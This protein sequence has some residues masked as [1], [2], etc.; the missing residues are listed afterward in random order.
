MEVT[1]IFVIMTEIFSYVRYPIQLQIFFLE[2]EFGSTPE[3]THR[4]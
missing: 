3:N 4:R 2:R 1:G